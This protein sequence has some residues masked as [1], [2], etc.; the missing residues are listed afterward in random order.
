MV[1]ERDKNWS[2]C[3]IRFSMGQFGDKW[4]FLIIRDLM[5]KNRKYYH[6]FLE[7]GEGIST[8]ILAKRLVDLET[9]NIIKKKRDD[10]KKSRFIYS[11]TDKG[12]ELMPIMLAIID[13]SEK[14][15]RNTEVPKDFIERLRKNSE[16]LRTELQNTLENSK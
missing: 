3:P 2:G 15:D 6:E 7:A 13:W 9:K 10:V 14:H 12:S 11:L 4:S 8:N 5:F 1:H 16:K